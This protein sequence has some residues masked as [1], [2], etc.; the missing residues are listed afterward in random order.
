MYPEDSCYPANR[1]DNLQNLPLFEIVQTKAVPLRASSDQTARVETSEI[2]LQCHNPLLMTTVRKPLYSYFHNIQW[3]DSIKPQLRQAQNGAFGLSVCSF[4]CPQCLC[5]LLLS[6]PALIG[7]AVL[8]FGGPLCRLWTPP[9]R[10]ASVLA[11]FSSIAEE[12][13]LPRIPPHLFGSVAATKIHFSHT[14]ATSSYVCLPAPLP[15]SVGLCNFLSVCV[16]CLCTCSRTSAFYLHCR[17]SSHATWR[18]LNGRSRHLSFNSP[19]LF[20]CH[21]IQFPVLVDCFL[22]DFFTFCNPSSSAPS[23]PCTSCAA[24]W[25]G[26]RKAVWGLLSLCQS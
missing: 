20:L 21:I 1:G 23:S 11:A 18:F 12:E 13:M 9:P 7:W 6:L 2:R 14:S 22:F 25:Q 15:V 3:K 19:L 26:G 24:V 10:P 8:D 17:L 5:V 4:V 16:F